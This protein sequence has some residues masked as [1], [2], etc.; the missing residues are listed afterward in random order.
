[1]KRWISLSV[2]LSIFIV[3]IFAIYYNLTTTKE[4]YMKSFPKEHPSA[5][6]SPPT[7]TAHPDPT[8]TLSLSSP[9]VSNASPQYTT[10]VTTVSTTNTDYYRTME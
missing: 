6:Q 5:Q 1:M 8:V 3:S 2:S 4:Y 10:P 9:D 7:G